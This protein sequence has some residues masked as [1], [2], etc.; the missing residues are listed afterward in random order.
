MSYKNIA[1]VLGAFSRPVV[2]LEKRCGRCGNPL[3]ALK[4]E[5]G[6]D[7]VPFLCDC[8]SLLERWSTVALRASRMWRVGKNETGVESDPERAKIA[9]ES[10]WL[11]L[12]GEI[13]RA[14]MH[15]SDLIR[16][17]KD[18]EKRGY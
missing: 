13:K 15:T 1:E 4:P 11:A 7:A 5:S 2:A 17:L 12:S 18:L 6:A 10:E 16:Y 3:R 8:T 9:A 14:G